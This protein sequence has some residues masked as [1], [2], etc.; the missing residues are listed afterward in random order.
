MKPKFR[1]LD[2]WSSFL[3]HCCRCCHHHRRSS[4]C[5]IYLLDTLYAHNKWYAE[6]F[7]CFRQCEMNNE[8]SSKEKWMKEIRF[9]CEIFVS[10]LVGWLVFTCLLLLPLLLLWCAHTLLIE[11]SKKKRK[12]ERSKIMNVWYT[13]K[14]RFHWFVSQTRPAPVVQTYNIFSLNC[15]SCT[16]F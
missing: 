9:R 8:E 7:H 1:L 6:I 16:Y 5:S 10:A 12:K 2:M 15:E 11:A 3:W 14:Y 4:S 13:N